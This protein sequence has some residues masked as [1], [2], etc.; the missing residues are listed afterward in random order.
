MQQDAPHKDEIDGI[1]VWMLMVT[2]WKNKRIV[3]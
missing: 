2:T 1:N 3:H